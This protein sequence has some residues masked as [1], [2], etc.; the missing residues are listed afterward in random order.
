MMNIIEN[1]LKNIY[2][3]QNIDLDDNFE[4]IM[5]IVKKYIEDE[6]ITLN[7]LKRLKLQNLELKMTTFYMADRFNFRR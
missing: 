3:F 5:S 7:T 6:K 1:L 2:K 4:R